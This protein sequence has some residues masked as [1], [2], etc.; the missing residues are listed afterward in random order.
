MSDAEAIEVVHQMMGGP[1]P[2]SGENRGSRL[3]SSHEEKRLRRHTP[4]LLEGSRGLSADAG[5][6]RGICAAAGGGSIVRKRALAVAAAKA[7]AG[8]FE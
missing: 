6:R 1:R 2:R 4:R 5:M 7:R 3:A 8:S